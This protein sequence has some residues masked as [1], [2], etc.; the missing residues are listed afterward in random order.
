[1]RSISV[2]FGVENLMA[3]FS[4][5]LEKPILYKCHKLFTIQKQIC[6]MVSFKNIDEEKLSELLFIR[7]SLMEYLFEIVVEKFI[8]LCNKNNIE[9]IILGS[10]FSSENTKYD[11]PS[12]LLVEMIKNNSNIEVHIE[13]ESYTSKC[14]S[15]ALEEIC[16]HR[17]Y[18][19]NRIT[20]R[21]YVSSTGHV[22]DSDVNGAINIYRKY[23]KNDDSIIC[24]LSHV[25]FIKNPEL[26][27]IT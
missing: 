21:N 12:Y 8:G 19:G 26:I 6:R 2:D 13:D 15:L 3:L 1:M 11:L 27:C 17:N 20:K 9:L 18:L 10:G 22:I 4:P 5:L 24:Y 25:E 16:F 23:V 14:D 7:N